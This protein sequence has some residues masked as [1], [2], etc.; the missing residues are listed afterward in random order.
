MDYTG[1]IAIAVIAFWAMGLVT[2]MMKRSNTDNNRQLDC[3]MALVDKEKA[4]IAA[5]IGQIRTRASNGKAG[6][7]AVDAQRTKLAERRKNLEKLHDD[8][9]QAGVI[10]PEQEANLAKYADLS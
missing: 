9:N 5:S 6:S 8:I 4:V 7:A 10:T 1:T 2:W 3:I